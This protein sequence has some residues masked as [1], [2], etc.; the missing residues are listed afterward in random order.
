MDEFWRQMIASIQNMASPM[1]PEPKEISFIEKKVKNRVS[2][3][4]GQLDLKALLL[5][6]TPEIVDMNWPIGMEL[7][8]VDRSEAMADAFW[9][10]DIPGKRK[11][12]K[13]NWWDFPATASSFHFIFGDG[14]FNIQSF[15]GQFETFASRMSGLLHRNG[16]A[17]FRVFTRSENPDSPEK[18]IN[19][20][21]SGYISSYQEFR[22]RFTIALQED[23]GIGVA[24]S[25]PNTHQILKDMGVNVEELALLPDYSGIAEPM[26]ALN[27]PQSL[28][29]CFPSQQE[30]VNA[31]SPWLNVVDVG[32]GEHSLARHCPVFC[33]SRSLE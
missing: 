28:Q 17:F 29:M 20:L 9:L 31:V 6:V 32:Y 10:G 21:R 22:L 12:T 1:R 3:I 19:Q 11:L 30:F 15:P 13:G 5:G 16:L 33:L 25:I 24:S 23:A 8:A 27:K 14:I 7:E 26:L 18:V 2:G 4:D